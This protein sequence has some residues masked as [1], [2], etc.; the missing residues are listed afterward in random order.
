MF[1]GMF[2]WRRTYDDVRMCVAGLVRLDMYVHACRE[3][4]RETERLCMCGVCACSPGG[5]MPTHAHI[6]TRGKA[7]SNTGTHKNIHIHEQVC[8]HLALVH[9]F[10]L[11]LTLRRFVLV[12]TLVLFGKAF[13]MLLELLITARVYVCA[14]VCVRMYVC[15]RGCA[16]MRVYVC[17]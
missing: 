3:A 7:R 4:G 1:L 16:G 12:G 9:G 13:G 14:F 11:F 8:W 15:L 2:R 10:R 17:V 6:H 5:R